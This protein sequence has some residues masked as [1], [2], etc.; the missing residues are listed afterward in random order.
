MAKTVDIPGVGKV[1][2]KWAVAGGLAVAGIV[3][4]AYWRYS[5]NN[6]ALENAGGTT[7]FTG[8][9]GD[10]TVYPAYSTDYAPDGSYDGGAYPYPSYTTPSYGLTTTTQTA[11]PTTNSQW[12]QRS[13]EHLELVGV[14]SQAGS[15]AVSRYLLKEC[16]TATQ[17][18][19][20]RQAVAALGPPPQGTFS[21]VV[22]PTAPPAGNGQ[23]PGAQL[24]A[25]TGGRVSDIT[26]TSIRV[27]WNP[28]A[29][30]RAYACYAVADAAGGS[31]PTG[32][33]QE[34]VVTPHYRFRSLKRNTRYRMDIH[35]VGYDGKIG[36]RLRLYATTEK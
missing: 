15:L 33:I 17:A 23:T 10:E 34:T 4:V 26:P 7:D 11:D 29:G 36:G 31:T 25:P 20:V 8:A 24:A 16:V 6:A 13:I 21:I 12:T 22:C 32:Q 19:M 35:P 27:D 18:D 1:P 28:V 30:A 5:Q 9:T 14:E 3:G 2:T